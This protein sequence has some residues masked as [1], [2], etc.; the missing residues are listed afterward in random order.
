[1]VKL[2]LD[3]IL[4]DVEPLAT[5]Q[6]DERIKD[7]PGSG[8]LMLALYQYRQLLA[9][10]EKGFVRDF[11]HGGVEPYYPPPAEGEKADYTKQRVD[12]EVLRTNLAGVPGRWFFS[13]RDGTL[14]GFEIIPVDGDPCEVYLSD[15]K[16]VD[17]RMLPH[18]IDVQYGKDRYASLTVKGYKLSEAK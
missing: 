15:Y 11:Y 8:G 17:G 6:D 10:G 5:K 7:P 16:A 2:D 9:F 18:R 1:V 13:P 4:Y 3:G 14:L 12:C